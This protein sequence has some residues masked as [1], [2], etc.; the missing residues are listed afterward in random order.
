MRP[1]LHAPRSSG[2]FRT[3]TVSGATSGRVTTPA[4]FVA[5]VD[6][7]V[8]SPVGTVPPVNW[9][10]RDAKNSSAIFLADESMSRKPIP[11]RPELQS[12]THPRLF[13]RYFFDVLTP[14]DA[15]V[16]GPGVIQRIPHR[17]PRC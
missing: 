17:L 11:A 8:V 5:E 10:L 2:V 9:R 4:G 15:F 1:P 16:E 14:G 13:V 7:P 6:S 12:N 3:V